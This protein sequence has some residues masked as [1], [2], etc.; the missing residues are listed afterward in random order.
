MSNVTDFHLGQQVA[1]TGRGGGWDDVIGR[2]DKEPKQGDPYVHIEYL[3]K[4]P[5][6]FEW[7]GGDWSPEY[8]VINPGSPRELEQ[9]L[10]LLKQA[11]SDERRRLVAEIDDL[12]RVGN[13]L[14]RELRLERERTTALIREKTAAEVE[15][16]DLKAALHEASEQ[17]SRGTASYDR[18]RASADREIDRLL[19][20]C[21]AFDEVRQRD[22]ATL[23]EL[24]REVNE[25]HAALDYAFAKLLNQRS[26][27]RLAGFR[28]G[29]AQRCIDVPTPE[30]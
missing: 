7:R 28:D 29:Y 18:L 16:E 12:R 8:L 22:H 20:E 27:N 3:T 19:L 1:I 14:N 17:I 30:H 26:R 23:Q 24:Y 6:D 13:D 21:K 10:S 9:E 4:I 2:V 11:A 15:V 5:N 25:A